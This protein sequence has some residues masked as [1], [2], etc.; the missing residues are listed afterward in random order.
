M[1]E[2]GL[3]QQDYQLPVLVCLPCSYKAVV[4]EPLVTGLVHGGG[5]IGDGKGGGAWDQVLECRQV[6]QSSAVSCIGFE[7]L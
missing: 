3:P 1:N 6:G 5:L 4:A 2:S 7:S